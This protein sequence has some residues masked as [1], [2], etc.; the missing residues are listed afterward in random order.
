VASGAE[1]FTDSLPQVVHAIDYRAHVPMA[2]ATV[3]VSGAGVAVTARL[4]QGRPGVVIPRRRKQPLRDGVGEADI[5][6]SDI[7][8]SGE[9]PA[10]SGAEPLCTSQG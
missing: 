4:A 9:T 3:Y 8:N 6:A 7:A 5:T 2:E 10:K 1:T